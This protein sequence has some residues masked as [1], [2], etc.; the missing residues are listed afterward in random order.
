MILSVQN[1]G[2]NKSIAK[3]KIKVLENTAQESI[4]VHYNSSLFMV[5]E[6]MYYKIYCLNSE[7][8]KLSH[9]S[10]IAYLELVDKE[11]E[12]VFKQKIRL[13]N[14]F[15]QGDFF[16]PVDTRSG[17]YKLVAYTKWMSNWG[18][19]I[20]F[21]DDVIILNPYSNNQRDFL[22][23]EVS[24]EDL[25]SKS[26]LRPSN[27]AL[28]ELN[29]SP[30]QLFISKKNYG[31]RDEVIM[32]FE[33]INS[34]KIPDGEYSISV[35]KYSPVFPNQKKTTVDHLESKEISPPTFDNNITLPE[36]RGELVTGRVVAKS[37][38]IPL[39]NLKIAFSVPGEDYQ[40]KIARTDVL[41]QFHA[42]ITK[43]YRSE[44]ILIQLIDD[45]VDGLTI[46]LDD[47]ASP[48]NSDKVKF[49]SFRL[50]PEMNDL[51]LKRSIQNQIENAYFKVKPD[52]ITSNVNE[53]NFYGTKGITYLLDDYTRFP[54]IKE[55]VL[56]ILDNVWLTEN[57]NDKYVFN[58][59]T[60]NGEFNNSEFTSL[61]IVDGLFVKDQDYFINNFSSNSIEQINIV[62]EY[63]RMGSQIFDGIIDIK[64]F[65]QNYAAL[66]SKNDMTALKLNRQTEIKNYF[67]QSYGN[68]SSKDLERI[69][70]LRQQLLWLPNFE[71][72]DTQRI[73][74]F[75]SD[76][77]GDFEI[78]I[79]GFTH[80]GK[81]VSILDTITVE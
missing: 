75:T 81:P 58:L 24:K 59:R 72:D 60:L 11:G 63:Y 32:E 28:S 77:K 46:E 17:N 71:I 33:G 35:R 6:Y 7:T 18:Q 78:S 69:P 48:F 52:T 4:F 8:N 68:E 55:T 29:K 67:R 73:T 19:E 13:D 2:Q 64:T 5:G 79:E 62:K 15:G 76:L 10:K 42:N 47:F 57:K 12:R 65:D 40:L 14:G 9:I 3:D 27:S 61:L 56:E 70:D 43:P 80:T 21:S 49:E 34:K 41:G 38:D 39:E 37:T 16:L 50:N 66:A 1:Y 26:D 74:F 53:L 31:K 25:Q 44:E 30:L 54:T 51:I 20:F 36:L 22:E 45:N 23:S